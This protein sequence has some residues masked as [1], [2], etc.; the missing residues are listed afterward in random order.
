MDQIIVIVVMGVF[1]QVQ[2]VIGILIVVVYKVFE[3]IVMV[4]DVV[5]GV[6]LGGVQYFKNSLFEFWCDVFIGIDY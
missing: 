3:K 5:D 4:G 2:D 1:V 6:V